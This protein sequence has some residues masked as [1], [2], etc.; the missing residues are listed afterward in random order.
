M[1][2]SA[3]VAWM[4]PSTPGST[5]ST[6]P[7][8]QLGT[9]PAAGASGRR[10]RYVAQPGPWWNTDAWP[11]KRRI[12]AYTSGTPRRPQASSMRYLV[13]KLSQP[14]RTTS[15]PRRISSALASVSRSRTCFTST[16]GF[17]R[18]NVSAADAALG[19]PT[20]PLACTICRWR[21]DTST[22]SSSTM[23]S[24]PTP[25]AARYMSAGEPRP[26]AP[27]QQTEPALSRAWPRMP[28]SSRMRWRE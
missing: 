25:A 12:A 15:W 20:A 3:S 11:S 7:S 1:I 18:F 5:P 28:T 17:T 6:P 14:S 2:F 4:Q 8:A 26:P 16:S 19:T 13:G 9:A 24:F 21:F 22:S 27:T 23:V 10:S